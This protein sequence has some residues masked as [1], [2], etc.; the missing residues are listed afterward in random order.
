MVVKNRHHLIRPTLN[1]IGAM[2]IVKI[3][4]T[5]THFFSIFIFIFICNIS[6]IQKDRGCNRIGRARRQGETELDKVVMERFLYNLCVLFAFLYKLFLLYFANR[7]FA[8]LSSSHFTY[9]FVCV[10]V[11]SLTELILYILLVL[12]FLL[13]MKFILCGLSNFSSAV[14][15]QKHIFLVSFSM[16]SLKYVYVVTLTSK[17]RRSSSRSR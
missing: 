8:I 1:S 13:L 17:G 3:I 16:F 15:L 2:I 5:A 6:G 4:F 11:F 14:I 7:L 9:N 12:M 10:C